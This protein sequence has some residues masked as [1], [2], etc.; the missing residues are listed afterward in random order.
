MSEQVE[1]GRSPRVSSDC[2]A[3]LEQVYPQLHWPKS[4]SSFTATVA[5]G[6]SRVLYIPSMMATLAFSLVPLC[7][8]EILQMIHGPMDKALSV[9]L[10]FPTCLPFI[11]FAA[12][13]A[14]AAGQVC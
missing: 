1:D 12:C 13:G 3:D 9:T 2:D 4:K 14:T 8:L 7:S 10:G 6:I 11:A 5:H